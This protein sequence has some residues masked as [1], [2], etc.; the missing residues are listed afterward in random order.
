[1]GAALAG[2]A[3]AFFAHEAQQTSSNI[4]AKPIMKSSQV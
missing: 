1:M 2:F 3:Q 4:K